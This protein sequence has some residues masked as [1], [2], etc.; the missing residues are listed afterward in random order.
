MSA[1]TVSRRWP[2]GAPPADFVVGH[3][4]A[5]LPDRVLDDA[6]VAVR[7][8]RIAEVGP[9]PAGSGADVDGA[10]LLCMPGLVDV[11][12]DGLE[13][14]RRPRPGAEVPW[15]FAMTSYE[16]VMRAAG[17]TTVFH[18]ASFE[19]PRDQL[20][21]RSVTAAREMCRAVDAHRHGMVE[22]RVLHRLD[23]RCPDGLT[24]LHERLDEVADLGEV[25]VVSH[26]DHTPGQGQ[27]A[28]RS[29][30]ERY[31]AGT[32][33][34]DDVAARRVTDEAIAERDARLAVRDASVT[35]LAGR[36]RAGA[37]RLFGH[38]PVDADDV[39]ELVARGAA[40]AEFPTTLA[41]A[42]AAREHGMSIVAGAP[43]VLR[44]GS[45]SGNVAALELADAGLVDAL[46]SDYLPPGLL[47]AVF[48][49]VSRGSL[50]LPAATA[51]VTAG[52]AAA[53]GLDDRGRLEAGRRA[54]LVLVEADGEWPVV[55][56]VL[57]AETP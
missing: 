49:L 45:H 33:G 52:P 22:H 48:V 24:A 10:G 32:H 30:Y 43:N 36:A 31:L 21:R 26:E 3:V 12:S 53:V 17:V 44:G 37:V 6:R 23:V 46:A 19:E 18:G 11:H 14:A 1:P 42:R 40:V 51:L 34:I 28:D 39:S 41:A 16:G 7:G 13:R 2:L 47:A 8:G 55:R 56:T 35:M 27:Y 29:Y 4:R 20:S 9:H 5:V 15:P 50:D 57:R 54:D 38:D 25:A